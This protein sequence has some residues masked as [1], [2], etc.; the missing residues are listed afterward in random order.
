MNR[1]G[2][3]LLLASAA[4]LQEI[5]K[6]AAAA[7]AAAAAAVAVAVVWSPLTS[8]KA[9]S[10]SGSDSSSSSDESGLIGLPCGDATEQGTCCC[11]RLPQTCIEVSIQQQQQQQQQWQWHVLQRIDL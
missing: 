3:L 1:A 8:D 7:A 10:L 4:D 2:H 9:V 5:F 11:Q 6:T